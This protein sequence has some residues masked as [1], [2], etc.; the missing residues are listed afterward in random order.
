MLLY[1]FALER[2]GK[3]R[4]GREIV[5]AGVLY[6]PARSVTVSADGDLTDEEVALERAKQLRRSGLILNDPA[7]LAAMENDMKPRYI[8]VKYSKDGV[9]SG[10]ALAEA[11]Q[12]GQLSRYI[13]ETLSE[14][15]GELRRGSIDA[16]P[17]YRSQS[18]NACRFCQLADACLFIEG[19][20]QRR[21]QE[22][23]KAGEV[24]G[25]IEDRVSENAGEPLEI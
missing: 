5:P 10:D 4:Y 17:Y 24:W 1:L 8:P 25:R 2:E 21:Y 11:Q 18:E 16:D 19:Q 6:V 3:M 13:D 14:L 20:D 23:L 15:A 12:L 7:V 9:P 22:K